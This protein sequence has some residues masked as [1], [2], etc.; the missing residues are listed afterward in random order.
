MALEM[1]QIGQWGMAFEAWVNYEG[2]M[3][4]EAYHCMCVVHSVLSET[5]H[6][7]ETG[8]GR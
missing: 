7:L 8:K 2:E 4:E 3:T 5:C 6:R 1:G